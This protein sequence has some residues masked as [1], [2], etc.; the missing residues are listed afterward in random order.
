MLDI[1]RDYICEHSTPEFLALMEVVFATFERIELQDY[2]RQYE[3]I[4]LTADDQELNPQQDSIGDIV[5]LTHELLDGI[6]REHGIVLVE[7]VSLDFAEK[8]LTAFLDLQNREVDDTL[9]APL[10][11][12]GNPAEMV[13][14][15]LTL[16]TPYVT[17]EILVNFEEVDPLV[18]ERIRSFLEAQMM[19]TPAAGDTALN[20]VQIE[21]LCEAA[22]VQ[23]DALRLARLDLPLGLSMATY[24]S[25][26]GRELDQGTVAEATY[27]LLAACFASHD[28]V[29]QPFSGLQAYV[30]QCI[31]NLDS[32]TR[33]TVAAKD[34]ILKISQK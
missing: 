34:L 24:V 25:A 30:E 13:A 32:I 26:Y 16:F 14:E 19:E 20:R 18:P 21:K 23:I 29:E 33:I 15:L 1:L 12:E 8:I 3:E 5:K 10:S 4:L 9:L 7:G 31:S 27:E 28:Y 17:D 6:L 22:G 11:G 2:E